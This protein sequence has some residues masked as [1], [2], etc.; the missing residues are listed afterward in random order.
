MKTIKLWAWKHPL[1]SLGFN[2][3]KTD[4]NKIVMMRGTFIIFGDLS[5]LNSNLNEVLIRFGY[6]LKIQAVFI[7]KRWQKLN[8]HPS[9]TSNVGI[10]KINRGER[11]H[12]RAIPFVKR[13]WVRLDSR[14]A[15]FRVLE[16]FLIS[17]L[18]N[19]SEKEFFLQ[20]FWYLGIF[21]IQFFY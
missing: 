11:F 5:F 14:D 20:D 3:H 15:R 9:R 18:T 21:F 19:S 10:L 6:Y 1:I 8:S 7:C 13:I 16:N 4:T 17:S 12:M 2:L